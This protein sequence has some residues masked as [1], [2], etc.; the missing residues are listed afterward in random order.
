VVDGFDASAAS[1]GNYQLD[2]FTAISNPAC[3]EVQPPGAGGTLHGQRAYGT[4]EQWKAFVSNSKFYDWT[5]GVKLFENYNGVPS[6]VLDL[7][8][9]GLTAIYDDDGELVECPLSP[10]TFRIEFWPTDPETNRPDFDAQ[11]YCVY[12]VT[13]ANGLTKTDSGHRYGGFT[14][15]AWDVVLPNPCDGTTTGWLSIQNQD[16][17]WFWWAGSPEGGTIHVE[18]DERTGQW[19]DVQGDLAYCLTG[20]TSIQLLGACCDAYNQ[21]P[22]GCTNNTPVQDCTEFGMFFFP[23]QQ[24]N[25]LPPET[26]YG[27]P[28][29]AC[30]SGSDCFDDTTYYF[31]LHEGGTWYEGESCYNP[32]FECPEAGQLACGPGASFSHNYQ[33]SIYTLAATGAPAQFGEWALY[34]NYV[35]SEDITRVTWWGFSAAGPQNDCDLPSPFQVKISFFPTASGGG[36]DIDH[37]H[38]VFLTQAYHAPTGLWYTNT[39]EMSFFEAV[40]PGVATLHSGWVAMQHADPNTGNCIMYVINGVATSGDLID[41]V[42]YFRENSGEVIL[43]P[44]QDADMQFCLYSGSQ[45]GA[46]CDLATGQCTDNVP[47]NDCIGVGKTFYLN[48][49]DCQAACAPQPGACCNRLTGACAVTLS[50]EC[51]GPD[52]QWLGVGS[53]CDECCVVLCPQGGTPEGEPVCG[54][55]YVDTYNGGCDSSPPVFQPITAGQMVCGESGLFEYQG[56]MARDTDWYEATLTGIAGL[57]WYVQAEFLQ[58][59]KILG[60]CAAAGMKPGDANCNG[61]VD[62][63]DIQPFVQALTNPSAWE[64]TYPDCSL[65]CVCDIDC[66]GSVDGFDIQPFVQCLT[67]QCPPCDGCGIVYEFGLPGAPTKCQVTPA[68]A[69]LQPGTYWLFVSTFS[70]EAPYPECGSDYVARYELVGAG[71]CII[72]GDCDLRTQNVCLALGGTYLGDGVPCP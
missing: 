51:T 44:F 62:G 29:A 20:D 57:R 66:N 40:L 6:D 71:A 38:A 63:F 27:L 15:W 47:Q 49:G 5:D 43:W 35:V 72:G 7:H 42:T 32:G 3:P 36:P 56:Q 69:I 28:T 34:D 55:D 17:C 58:D 25:Q 11:P 64:A 30:C 1:Y 23:N 9:W 46:C 22:P 65:Y 26:C 37:P 18:L 4:Y 8:W 67:G 60:D 16:L 39:G 13:A 54:Q 19:K 41:D 68:F 59:V 70:D 48:L 50:S 2:I 24:C 21:Y 12:T 10:G 45:I 53:T 14:L 61:T 33:D 52:E 31:C